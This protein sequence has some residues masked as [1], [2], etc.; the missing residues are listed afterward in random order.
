MESHGEQ[1]LSH[2]VANGLVGERSSIGFAKPFCP[3]AEMRTLLLCHRDSCKNPGY[4]EGR[5]IERIVQGDLKFSASCQRLKLRLALIGPVVW[6]HPENVIL[7]DLIP[8]TVLLRVRL[9]RLLALILWLR[10]IRRQRLLRNRCPR[11]GGD[12]EGNQKAGGT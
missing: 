6:N 8:F 5:R 4:E 2:K 1:S 12:T 3:L 9:V 7:A 11:H 10:C